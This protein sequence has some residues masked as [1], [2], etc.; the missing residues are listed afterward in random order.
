[1]QGE[2][3]VLSYR[4]GSFVIPGK[5]GTDFLGGMT[6]PVLFDQ[7]RREVQANRPRRWRRTLSAVGRLWVVLAVVWAA[8]ATLAIAPFEPVDTAERLVGASGGLVGAPEHP[9]RSPDRPAGVPERSAGISRFPFV[10]VGIDRAAAAST[11]FR[12]SVDSAV[13]QAEWQPVGPGVEYA[14]ITI[15]G[16]QPFQVINVLRVERDN[17]NVSL[18][19][20]VGRGQ[21]EGTESVLSQALRLHTAGPRH[22]GSEPR[23][24]GGLG[25]RPDYAVVGGVNADFFA[26]APV[27]GLPIGL[28]VQDGDIVISPNDR[29]VFAVL[30]DGRPIIGVPQMTGQVWR[31]SVPVHAGDGSNPSDEL[32]VRAAV[33]DVN[34]PPNGLGLVVY[35]PSFG[36]ETP[37]IDGIAVTLRGIVGP[38]RSGRVYSGVVVRNEAGRGR[39][40][41]RATIPADGVVLAARG[42][43]EVL[44]E[45]LQP[46]EWVQLQLNL[47]SPFE[48]VAHAVAG[49]P[50]LVQN[51]AALQLNNADSL[52]S[53]RHPRTAVGYNDRETFLVT[54]DGRQGGYA[55]GMTLTELADLMIALGA[56]EALNLDGGGSTTFVVRPPGEERPVVAN[57]PSDG[58][59]RSVANALFVVS[60]APPAP[61][62]KLH[63]LP[64]SPAVLEGGTLPVALRGQDRHHGPVA[65]DPS[66]V[67]WSITRDADGMVEPGGAGAPGVIGAPDVMAQLGV[68][69]K[70]NVGHET[71][72]TGGA[73]LVPGGSGTRIPFAFVAQS[74][75]TVYVTARVG[76]VETTIAIDV[77]PSSSVTHIELSPEMIHLAAGETVIPEVQA[78]DEAGRRV[79]VNAEQ[80]T[81]TVAEWNPAGS[82]GAVVAVDRDGRITGLTAG[83]ATVQAR[84]GG[85]VGSVTVTVDRPPVL[86]SEF[87]TPGQW[88]ANSVRAQAA[89]SLTGP[90]EPVHSG[91]G[92]GKLV[93]DLSVAPGGTAAAYVQATAPIPIPDRPRSL[94]IWVYGDQ[95]GHWLRANYLD[96]EGNRHVLDFTA[97]GGLNW[98]GWRFLEA[99]I[100]PDAMP[101]LTFE[102]VYVV[103]MHRERQTR[104][105]LYFDRLV[106]M[107]GRP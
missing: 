86:L 72:A 95:S 100:P 13:Q 18:V 96:G 43:A 90:P 17:P 63:V 99:P 103:E 35:T 49:W 60:T 37:A 32:F 102:R 105:V 14:V 57:R 31:D 25:Q 50:I 24:G 45:D 2:M 23:L 74:P 51:G 26:S 64:S 65:V 89:F 19:A 34:R 107:Y 59:E 12:N 36:S 41:V 68:S 4:V 69:A 10:S 80:L 33:N 28:H 55:E 7:G 39:A 6:V 97:V 38:V 29:P 104:G 44:L 92:A 81:W 46:G 52:V 11:G 61:L 40:A 71:G 1:M 5:R 62:A 87:E 67:R 88:F 9:S 94:G 30:E 27:S 101:P 84:L 70:P 48:R 66:L 85:A 47:N 8:M 75:G 91:Q 79:W 78:F 98:T 53:G 58:H 3:H 93:Y 76:A 22:D 82:A 83:Q 73:G 42:P 54:V 16:P 15:N 77:V 21:V 56:T 20:S 106:A